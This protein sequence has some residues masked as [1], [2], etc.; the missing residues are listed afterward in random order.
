MVYKIDGNPHLIH[1]IGA[2]TPTSLATLRKSVGMTQLAPE[3]AVVIPLDSVLSRK[4][5]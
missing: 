5:R 1:V 4:R 3:D 2:C